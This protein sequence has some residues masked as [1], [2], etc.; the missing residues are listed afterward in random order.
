MRLEPQRA[1]LGEFIDPDGEQSKALDQVVCT[2]FRKSRSYT[3]EDVVELACHGS[4][5]VLARLLE[6][7]WPKARA[8]PNRANLRCR[9]S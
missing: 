2:C 9:P 8:Q 5:V 6:C 4:P 3:G 7:S 1:V